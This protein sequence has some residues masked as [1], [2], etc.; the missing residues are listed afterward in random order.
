MKKY[1][2]YHVY[3][4]D[5]YSTWVYP[6]ME[7][8]KM[9]EDHHLLSSFDDITITCV[10]QQDERTKIFADLCMSFALPNAKLIVF[11]NNHSN[12]GVMLS[13]INN[14]ETITENVI[15]Q[16]IWNDSQ[17]DDFTALYLH[18]KGITSVD[19]HLKKR[20]IDTFKNYYYW[21]QFLN[22]GV[23]ENWERCVESL[24]T[25]DVAGVNY[26]DEPCPHFS[27]NFWWSNSSY[28][29]RLPDP[30]TIDWWKNLQSKTRDS[31][32]RT[33]PDRF[34]DEM[35]VCSDSNAKV[36]SVKNLDTVTN[37]SAKL[38]KRKEYV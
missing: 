4:S 37:L 35:W 34:R 20:N 11:K 2:Y 6:F 13:G 29:R 28:L 30:S 36:Y 23:I 31:W 26:F 32:L 1:L 21:R 27:G 15:L 19:N 7:Q 17:N 33:A 3:L 24:N 14:S 22:W 8:M 5:E 12:D 38:I 25:H 16:R 9:M 18:T 10:S